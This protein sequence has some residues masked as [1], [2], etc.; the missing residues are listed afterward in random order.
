MAGSSVILK[1]ATKQGRRSMGRLPNNTTNTNSAY[2]TVSASANNGVQV[3]VGTQSIQQAQVGSPPPHAQRKEVAARNSMAET[4]TIS[5]QKGNVAAGGAG[6]TTASSHGHGHGH[7]PCLNLD[8][9]PCTVVS[10]STSASAYTNTLPV[11]ELQNLGRVDH[12]FQGAT[13]HERG[14]HQQ[15][16]GSEFLR[17]LFR[18]PHSSCIAV[19]GSGNQEPD[20]YVVNRA[21]IAEAHMNQERLRQMVESLRKEN[22]QLKSNQN[23]NQNQ[24]Q[25]QL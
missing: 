13:T 25:Q 22:E 23:Q 24:N 21:F 7:A 17:Q 10:T 1:A 16:E 6:N 20:G 12:Y 4:T 15:R 9:E 18:H 14:L 11:H 19:R 3:L 2:T 5:K 8:L